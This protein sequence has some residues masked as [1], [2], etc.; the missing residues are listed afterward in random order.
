MTIAFERTR[1][2]SVVFGRLFKG[3]ERDDLNF[4]VTHY[5][6][7]QFGPQ[8]DHGEKRRR[9]LAASFSGIVHCFAPCLVS[10]VNR[11]LPQ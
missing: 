3:R 8:R 2:S 5:G 10:R 4:S 6:T 11:Q 9:K 7:P 1:E